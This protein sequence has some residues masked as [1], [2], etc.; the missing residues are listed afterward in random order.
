MASGGGTDFKQQAQY[1]WNRLDDLANVD[2]KAYKSFIDKQMK[3]KDIFMSNPKAELCIHT[4]AKIDS[5]TTQVYVNILSWKRL[6][7][8]KSDQDPIKLMGGKKS[9]YR[10]TKNEKPSMC[11]PVAVNDRIFGEIC[12]IELHKQDFLKLCLEFVRRQVKV[13]VSNCFIV[14][15]E[16]FVGVFP[17]NPRALFLS[18]MDLQDPM[19]LIGRG[20]IS[21]DKILS[22]PDALLKNLSVDE[23]A[24]IDDE[25]RK[26]FDSLIGG[27]KGGA[28]TV[29]GEKKKSKKLIEE[30]DNDP[31]T[32]EYSFIDGECM[33]VKIY[34]PLL[35]NMS[36]CDLTI[37]KDEIKLRACSNKYELDL[38]MP[39]KIDDDA[40][41]AK[42]NRKTYKL[43]LTA[44]YL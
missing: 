40:A 28:A 25:D 39:K 36:D 4:S 20:D 21:A 22:S 11:I 34:L 30:M 37:S 26:M 7:D 6:P 3:E 44:P 35:A 24:E 38:K 43:T 8:V 42:F 23:N 9:K 16:I 18:G 17:A 15:K 33:K 12:K 13:P 41:T 1:I 14:H 10:A 19:D 2:P 5:E 29:A 31:V 27:A 32:P